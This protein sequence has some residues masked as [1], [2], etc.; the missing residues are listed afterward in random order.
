MQVLVSIIPQEVLP[1]G[2]SPGQA[3]LEYSLSEK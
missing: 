1:K 3:L 2:R